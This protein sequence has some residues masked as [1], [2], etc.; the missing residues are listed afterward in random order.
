MVLSH[1]LGTSVL[2]QPIKDTPVPGVL[3]RWSDMG[4]EALCAGSI[5]LAEVLQGLMERDSTKYWRQ[6]RELL[7][8]RYPVLSFDAG[9][10]STYR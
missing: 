10:A 6:Y 2:S 4:D 9:V 1:L 7:E 3:K 5:C 8:N